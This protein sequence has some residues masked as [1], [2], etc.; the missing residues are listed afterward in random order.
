MEWMVNK[1]W[2]LATYCL[3]VFLKIIR[4]SRSNPVAQL[5][6]KSVLYTYTIW[7]PYIDDVRVSSR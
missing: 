3:P 7:L 2:L 6:S 1:W 4:G 5:N